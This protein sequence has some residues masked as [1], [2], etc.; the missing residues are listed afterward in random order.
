MAQRPVAIRVYARWPGV[1]A[2]ALVLAL[3]LGTL[4]VVAN[5][6]QSAS[7]SAADWAAVR[8][9]V[10]QATCSAVVSVG[11]AIPAARALARRRFFG[12]GALVTVLGA[13]FILPVIVAIFGILAAF[14]RNSVLSS[15]LGWFG[16]PPMSLYGLHGVVL[17]HV[18]FNLPLATRLILQGWLS[19]PA[20]RFRLAA[21][22]NAPVGRL[23]EWPMLRAV[24]PGVFIIVFLLCLT[25]F[26]VALTLGGGPKATTIELAI[27]QALRFD[28][29][30]G[31]A[32][33]LGLVQFGLCAVVALG[34]WAVALPEQLGA[35]LDRVVERW[36]RGGKVPDAFWIGLVTLFLALPLGMVFWRG[37][38]G[39]SQ[40]PGSVWLAA[41]RSLGVVALSV[42][43]ML[44]LSLALTLSP[45][46]G[47][48]LRANLFIGNLPLATSP[49][50]L[51][52][53]LFLLIFPLGW[54]S[55][56]ALP[57]T[58]LVNA[59]MCLP[60]AVAAL[61]PAVAQAEAGYGRLATSLG[62]H[63]WPRLRWLILPRLRRPL[64]FATGLTAALSMG[65]LGVIALFAGQRSETLPLAMSRL[66]GAYRMDAAAGAGLLLLMLSFSLFW[67][68]DQGGRVDAET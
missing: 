32:A 10:L 5:R 15:V 50:V 46:N 26:A 29:D 6:A 12:R 41:V 34:A 53:G 43:L 66:M 56:F 44:V 60:F 8:F 21:S 48:G 13:P 22:L 40:M 14:G 20:E 4:V 2:A 63:G 55:G 18:F 23:L 19:I 36:D 27:Y 49:L 24:A 25:S 51:G 30:L 61:T 17:A 39:W 45:K 64:G 31:K 42:M 68:F 57:V 54:V 62:L 11:L 52:T 28:F 47:S 33:L 59:V 16:L 67:L 35:G 3:T 9:T 1:A 65:D 58:A 37:I 7:L 38:P